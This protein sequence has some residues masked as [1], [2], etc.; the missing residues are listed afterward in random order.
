FADETTVRDAHHIAT[1][2]EEQICALLAPNGRIITHL[3][4]ISAEE[5]DEVWEGA[6]FHPKRNQNP[7]VNPTN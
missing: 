3:E 2:V 5:K 4:P 1:E 6:R 7:H